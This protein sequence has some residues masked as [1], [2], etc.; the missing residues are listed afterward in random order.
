[1]SFTS[2]L[3]QVRGEVVA[4]VGDGVYV[5]DSDFTRRPDAYLAPANA[6]RLEEISAAHDPEGRFAR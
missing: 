3:L 4:E 6:E 5:G 2:A 1:M